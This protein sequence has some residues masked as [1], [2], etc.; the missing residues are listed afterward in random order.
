[1]L[2]SFRVSGFR[3]FKEL[4]LDELDR[5]NLLAGSN[6]VGKTSLL[7]AI[8]IYI[9]AYNPELLIKL[10]NFRGVEKIEIKSGRNLDTPWDVCFHDFD[11]SKSIEFE[12]KNSALYS[13]LLRLKVLRD[14]SEFSLLD[15]VV[16]PDTPQRGG[17]GF[18]DGDNSAILSTSEYVRVLALE[19]REGD[20]RGKY[21]LIADKNGYQIKPISPPPPFPG[22]FLPSRLRISFKEEATLFGNL[23]VLGNQELLLNVLKII[24]PRLKRLSVVLLADE[25]ILHG[26]IGLGRLVPLPYMGE[27]LVRLAD[28]VMVIGNSPKGVV[29]IDEIEN[30]IHYAVLPKVWRAIGEAARE[31]NVQVFATTHSLECIMAAHRAFSGGN[32]YDFRLHR[33]EDVDG[34][35]RAITYDRESLEAAIDMGLE[36]R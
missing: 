27:G 12:G 10:N 8:F 23:D 32:T 19:Y 29:L 13:R 1:M 5:V 11:L 35:I 14:E 16:R 15:K 7:E 21:Y 31:F 25:P 30:G 22:H 26:D 2:K 9:G 17:N 33:L 28:L 6:N 36:V 24:E 4:H 3:C 34:K 18:G 20:K